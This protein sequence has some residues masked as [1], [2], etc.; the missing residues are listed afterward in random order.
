MIKLAILGSENSHA[1]GFSSVFAP[2]DGKKMFE[3]VELIGMHLNPE[4]EDG[5]IAMEKIMERS[6]I[7][8]FSSDPET[9][10]ADADAVMVTARH[11][12]DH[13]KFIRKYIEKG[14]PVW[15]D[16][17]ITASVGEAEELVAL[18]KKH[19][20]PVSGGSS[21]AHAKGVVK[22]AEYVKNNPGTVFGG[23]VT[24]PVNMVNNYGNFWFYSQHLVQM[25]TE[26]FGIEARKVSAVKDEHGVR[27][28]YFFD[29]YSVSAYFGSGY[30]VTLYAGGYEVVQE[31]VVLEGEY[32]IPELES[33]YKVIKTGKS[34]KDYR[35]LV[36]P[37]YIIDA[38][39]T[40]FETGK[41]TEIIIPEL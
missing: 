34:D 33:F 31:N 4:T 19:S 27:A 7:T 12:G 29:D 24:A 18:C 40:A 28:Q 35:T 1:W 39:I 14:I 23:H 26:I 8:E 38:T 15:V 6:T 20:A 5:K 30:S 10:V 9:F 37:V 13:L 11:G 2:K 32:Y 41:E 21:L 25:I 3:D 36:A 17:P 16:K 22:C